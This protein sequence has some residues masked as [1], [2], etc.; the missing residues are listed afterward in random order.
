M[1][2]LAPPRM[3]RT[4]ASTCGSHSLKHAVAVVN[5]PALYLPVTATAVA[6]TLTFTCYRYFFT[7]AMLPH[8]ARRCTSRGLAPEGWAGW[9]RRS[10]VCSD[11]VP[12]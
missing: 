1:R 5:G 12:T 4:Q 10:P 8:G 6:P 3:A 2:K 7:V 11:T 9:P